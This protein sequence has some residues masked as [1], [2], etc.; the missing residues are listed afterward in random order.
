[1]VN[2][3]LKIEH[4]DIEKKTFFQKE[5]VILGSV[6]SLLVLAYAGLLIYKASLD[7]KTAVVIDQYGSKLAT[8]QAGPA[9]RVFDFQNRLNTANNLIAKK[10]KTLEILQKFEEMIIAGVYIDSYEYESSKNK[11]TLN[12]IVKNYADM[13]RQVFSFKNSGYFSEVSV[14]NSELSESGSIKFPVVLII[15]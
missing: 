15:K 6:L 12:I 9:K 14:S 7:K 3:N 4:T 8:F 5:V 2:I 11:L 1:M 10:D 13:A